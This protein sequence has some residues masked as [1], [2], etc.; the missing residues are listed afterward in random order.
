MALKIGDK[1]NFSGQNGMIKSVHD[2]GSVFVV[3]Y[4]ENR[5][6]HYDKYTASRVK[7]EELKLGWIEVKK[8]PYEFA[9]HL[10]DGVYVHFSGYNYQFSV[11]SHENPAV[12]YMDDNV[13]DALIRF[14][15]RMI[16]Q[17]KAKQNV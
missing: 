7:I 14:R 2:E 10:G 9:D 13:I 16:A 1:V 6:E 15:E 3:F 11:N 8:D 12:F 4:C 17:A 5:W